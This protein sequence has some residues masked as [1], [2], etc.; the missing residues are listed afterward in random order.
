LNANPDL[1][2]APVGPAD[3]VQPVGDPLADALLFLAAHHGR[4]LS[5]EALLGG[6]PIDDGRLNV[7]L[8]ERAAQRAGLETEPVKRA[9]IDIPALVLPAVL[10]MRDGSCRV[11][12]GMEVRERT[13]TTID[14]SSGA[15]AETAPVSAL[16][17]GYL[18]YAF[19][20]RPAAATDAR[21]SAAGDDPQPHWF[22]SVVSRFWANYSH[23]AIAGHSAG[24]QANPPSIKTTLSFGK[25]SNTPSKTR[26]V[27]VFCIPVLAA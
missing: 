10:V 23:V 1:A 4:A 8:F 21:A 26:L 18:G 14:P 15:S 7:A 20:V 24:A 19:F 6:L 9:L 2:V 16:A 12:L 11:M 25:R 13:V 22:W 17:D 5:R 27:S 3:A